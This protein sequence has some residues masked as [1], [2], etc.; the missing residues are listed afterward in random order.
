MASKGGNWDYEALNGFLKSPKE[1]AARH[2]DELRR[3]R[4]GERT[5]PDVIA[6]LR[7]LTDNPAP[8]PE[9]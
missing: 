5:G 8:L 4:Q 7:S 6:Y 9:G 1:L 2:Q 3:P